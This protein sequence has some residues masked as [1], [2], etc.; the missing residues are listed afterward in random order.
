MTTALDGF[1]SHHKP[2]WEPGPHPKPGPVSR[3]VEL[4]TVQP[5]ASGQA[6]RAY[7]PTGMGAGRDRASAAAGAR[8]RAT[9]TAST[10]ATG[11]QLELVQGLG[12]GVKLG[13]GVRAQVHVR[14]FWS[15]WSQSSG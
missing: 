5:H 1:R 15:D 4:G 8:V 9:P 14:V 6:S 12:L 7:V 2:N 13:V 11:L 10:G 3:R